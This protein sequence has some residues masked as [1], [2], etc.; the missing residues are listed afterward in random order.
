MNVNIGTAG[1]SYKDWDGIVYPRGTKRPLQYLSQFI[2]TVEINSSFY[3]PPVSDT[4]KRWL[5]FT[6]DRVDFIFT[7]KL[8]NRFSHERSAS[9]L[10]ADEKIVKPGM[11][12]LAE[13]KKLGATLI[14]FPWSFKKTDENM[15][16]VGKVLVRFAA[17]HPFLEM[18]HGSWD[19]ADFLDLLSKSGAG[20]VNI[21]QPLIG[22]SIGLTAHRTSDRA[23]LR[24]H[25]RNYKNWFAD[26]A[27]GAARYNY[28]Y[29]TAELTDIL[30]T[31][32]PMIEKSAKSFIIYNNHY[33]GQA[34]SNALQTM[35]LL[36]EK[37]IPVPENMP[38]LY[39]ELQSIAAP[40]QGG[41]MTIF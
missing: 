20:F 28:L 32:L 24:L 15:A 27:D 17:Y 37:K 10:N 13:S 5:A 18:R 41:Q 1:W 16:W 33:R 30:D 6:A 26:N 38:D 21:D 14:Q 9:N 31:I 7:Y 8:W 19:S 2:N 34:V 22:K 4:V 12:V 23:Y 35:F 25:G 39:P 29:P 11:D 40:E 3:R 36:T